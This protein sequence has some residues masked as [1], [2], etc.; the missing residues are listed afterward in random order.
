M[1]TLSEPSAIW[2]PH[3]ILSPILPAGLPLMNTEL[4]PAARLRA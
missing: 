2:P 4:D 3:E 1:K